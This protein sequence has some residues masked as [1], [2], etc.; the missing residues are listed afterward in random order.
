MKKLSNEE[1]EALRQEFIIAIAK[2][3]HNCVF[4]YIHNRQIALGDLSMDAGQIEDEALKLADQ[5]A[6]SFKDSTIVITGSDTTN[7]L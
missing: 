6:K 3:A 4:K 7:Q 1:F 2:A 5:L